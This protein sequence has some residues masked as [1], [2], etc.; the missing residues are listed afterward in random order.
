MLFAIKKI[1]KLNEYSTEE[2]K[3]DI[4]VNSV[5]VKIN[6]INYVLKNRK[7]LLIIDNF[8]NIDNQSLSCF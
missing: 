3:H 2:I 4:S 5:L 6:Y 1:F 7:V 8:Q